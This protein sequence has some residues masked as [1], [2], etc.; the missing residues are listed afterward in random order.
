V[1]DFPRRAAALGED[2]FSVNTRLRILPAFA[3]A[4]VVV[5]AALSVVFPRDPTYQGRRLSAWL[6]SGVMPEHLT[7]AFQ[8]A[9]SRVAHA[10]FERGGIAVVVS[11]AVFVLSAPA[12]EAKMWQSGETL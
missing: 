12:P 1:I 9:S 8:S 6:R 5:L 4:A 10:Q 2:L 7:P 11:G 3:V